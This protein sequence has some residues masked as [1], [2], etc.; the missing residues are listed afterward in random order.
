M[1]G[2]LEIGAAL[3][4]ATEAQRGSLARFGRPLG[5]AF[6][7]RDDLLDGEGAHGATPALVNALVDEARAALDP[8]CSTPKPWPP[9]AR[10]PTGW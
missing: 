5:E 6:Q 8:G 1:A 9:S 4:G 10:W 3:A 7:L 2:P